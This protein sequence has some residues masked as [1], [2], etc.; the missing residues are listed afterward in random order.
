MKEPGI[1]G[2]N[3]VH[4]LLRIAPCGALV[5][6]LQLDAHSFHSNLHPRRVFTMGKQSKPTGGQ[7]SRPV[8]VQGISQSRTR[9]IQPRTK[10]NAPRF[11]TLSEA[12]RGATKSEDVPSQPSSSA[13]RP[14]RLPEQ[15]NHAGSTDHLLGLT[16]QHLET[17]A[18]LDYPNEE[19]VL[20]ALKELSVLSFAWITYSSLTDPRW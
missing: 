10:P 9:P 12:V 2:S 4:T 3:A 7:L 6:R 14:S 18:L 1:L 13:P 17:A 15:P 8:P 11:R 16:Q 5:H 20:E 19:K